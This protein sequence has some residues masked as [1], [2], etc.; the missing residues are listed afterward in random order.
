M[1]QFLKWIPL[2]SKC[3][4]HPLVEISIRYMWG[5]EGEGGVPRLLGMCPDLAPLTPVGPQK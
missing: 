4:P 2:R 1:K 3:V 5:R